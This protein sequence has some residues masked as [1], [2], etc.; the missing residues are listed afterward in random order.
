VL[1]RKMHDHPRTGSPADQTAVRCR[2]FYDNIDEFKFANEQVIRANHAHSHSN[3]PHRGATPQGPSKGYPARSFLR[4]ERRLH[5]RREP[6]SARVPPEL[7]ALIKS[8]SRNAPHLRRPRPTPT[9]AESARSLRLKS[10]SQKK[11]SQY[12]DTAPMRHIR[13][14][15][16]APKRIWSPCPILRQRVRSASHFSRRVAQLRAQVGIGMPRGATDRPLPVSRSSSR[17]KVLNNRAVLGS[18]TKIG[19]TPPSFRRESC[20]GRR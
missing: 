2:A 7:Q 12:C 15:R 10:W 8:L 14:G 20:K 9:A 3:H 1:R 6:V 11:P 19:K 16:S 13:F 4:P 17:E 5:R 18:A